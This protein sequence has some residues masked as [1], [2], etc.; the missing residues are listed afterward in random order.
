MRSLPCHKPLR[1]PLPNYG[2]AATALIR[3]RPKLARRQ[4]PA[5]AWQ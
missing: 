2:D 3:P 5:A 4:S 1:I